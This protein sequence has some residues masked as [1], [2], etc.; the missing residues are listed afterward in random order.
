V[1]DDTDR[2]MRLYK[3]L[4]D[5]TIR[6]ILLE[7]EIEALKGVSE[8]VI[9]PGAMYRDRGG[10]Y[11]KFGPDEELLCIW[12]GDGAG[13]SEPGRSFGDVNTSHG[14]LEGV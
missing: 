8:E 5:L 3:G 12:V 13:W 11:W 14:P 1:I 6:V 7:K 9:P 10:D 2:W 4:S